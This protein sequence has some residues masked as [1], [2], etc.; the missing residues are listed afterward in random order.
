MT[1]GDVFWHKRQLWL[2]LPEKGGRLHAM[3]CHDHLASAIIAYIDKAGIGEDSDGPL[4]RTFGRSRGRPLTRKGLQQPEAY[5]MIG[6]RATAAGI[7][8]RLSNHSFRATGITIY[9][10][11]GGTLEMAAQIAN[12]ASTRTTQL[13]AHHREKINLAEMARIRI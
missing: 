5:K 6:R 13:Y 8:T 7:T 3:P 1:V 4:F 9:L 11:N 2:R 12:H 10:N